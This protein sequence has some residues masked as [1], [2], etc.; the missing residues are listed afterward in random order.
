MTSNDFSSSL[1]RSPVSWHSC[2]AIS[3]IQTTTLLIKWTIV[4]SSPA[5]EELPR[6]VANTF[7]YLSVIPPHDR[8]GVLRASPSHVLR[9]FSLRNISPSV[10]CHPAAHSIY[11]SPLPNDGQRDPDD[12]LN[13][14]HKWRSYRLQI[15][16]YY[17]VVHKSLRLQ[18]WGER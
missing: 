4:T 16:R 14:P 12:N 18:Y 10:S 11:S 13:F 2:C 7:E 17:K 3:L 9:V 15:W 8:Q 5:D 1:I 6:R